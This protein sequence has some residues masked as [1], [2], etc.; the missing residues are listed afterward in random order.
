MNKEERQNLKQLLQHGKNVHAKT[1]KGETPLHRSAEEG[2][3]EVADLPIG[4]GSDV[5]AKTNSVFSF[6]EMP[7]YMSQLSTQDT[8]PIDAFIERSKHNTTQLQQL[9]LDASQVLVCTQER[10]TKQQSMGG[11]KRFWHIVSGKARQ[12]SL[13]NT[14]ALIKAQQLA[15]HFMKGLLVNQLILGATMLAI[16]HNLNQLARDLQETKDQMQKLAEYTDQRFAA[17]D[18]RTQEL[19]MD[20][21]ETKRLITQMAQAIDQRFTELEQRTE[22]LEVHSSIHT[23][24]NIIE[25]EK[26]LRQMPPTLRF[27]TVLKQFYLQKEGAQWNISELKLF[28]TALR[29]VELDHEQVIELGQFVANLVEELQDPNN[30][31]AIQN[32]QDLLH[33]QTPQG[34]PIGMEYLQENISIPSLL[35]LK[36]LPDSFQRLGPAVRVLQGNLGITALQAL[37]Q[38]VHNDISETYFIDLKQQ[39]SLF[40]LGAQLLSGFSLATNLPEAQKQEAQKQKAQQLETQRKQEAKQRLNQ[41]LQDNG[42][43]HIQAKDNNRWTP[44]HAAADNGNMEIAELL[45]QHGADVHAKTNIDSKFLHRAARDGKTE[46]D[47]KVLL[48]TVFS[49]IHARGEDDWTPL[50]LAA[51]NGKTEVANL[52]LEHDAD[53]HAKT[54]K[55]STPL[56]L[57]AFNG[58]TEVAKVLL[59]HGADVHA[60][61]NGST[62]LHLAAFNG[63]TEVAKVLLQHGADV[64]AKN[65]GSTPLHSAAYRGQTEVAELLLQHGADVNAKNKDGYTPLKMAIKENHKITADYLRSKGGKKR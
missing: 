53:V 33:L 10:L 17:Q 44:L 28:R 38:V 51:S 27:L 47:K 65:N 61:N 48:Y 56:H 41:W 13:A 40:E 19:A 58:K 3:T 45:L 25:D 23:W 63:K 21:Q 26:Y 60:K 16:K 6:G 39:L 22:R 7:L 52:L 4:K 29:K 46:V 12:D 32:Y 15:I 2:E 24:L 57:A 37:Q 8:Q 62:P 5:H 64:H 50:H 30:P 14:A 31:Q 1:N 9:A 34:Q 55:G 54:D 36:Q 43:R 20:L 42:F 59:Q 35:A 49:G 11:I 18:Q